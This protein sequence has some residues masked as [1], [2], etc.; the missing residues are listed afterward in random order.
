MIDKKSTIKFGSGDILI[1]PLAK[2]DL[3]KGCIV[4]QNQ[5][6]HAIGEHLK[7]FHEGEDDTVISFSNI[8]S[9]EVLIERLELLKSMM[10]GE[11]TNYTTIEYEY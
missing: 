4:L 11:N 7:G 2:T 1:T 9:L 3:S 8:E 6:P 10:S 5:E